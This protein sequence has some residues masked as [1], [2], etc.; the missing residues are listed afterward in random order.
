MEPTQEAST[1]PEAVPVAVAV[2]PGVQARAVAVRMVRWLARPG[3]A[4]TARYVE[5]TVG[6][7]WSRAAAG[8]SP[9]GGWLDGF[10]SATPEERRARVEGLAAWLEGAEVAPA[11]VD[12]SPRAVLLPAGHP[13]LTPRGRPESGDAPAGGSAEA[14]QP[15]ERTGRRDRRHDRHERRDRAERGDAR[16]RREDA[17]GAEGEALRRGEPPPPHEEVA[18]RPVAPAAPPPPPEPRTFPLGHPEGTGAALSTLGVLDDSELEALGAFGLATIS[19]LLL[20]PPVAVDR[21]GE[22]W[23]PQSAVGSHVVV[24]GVVRRRCVRLRPGVR[25]EELT[26][27]TERG[28]E[29]ACRWYG[30]VAPEVAALR[31]GGEVGLSGALE[32]EDDAHVLLQAEV[33][34][35]DGRGGDWFPRYE[36]PGVPD[37]R[38]RSALRAAFRQHLDALADHLPPELLEKHRLMPLAPAVRDAHFPPNAG[39]KGRSRLG[40]DELLQVQLGVALLRARERRDRGLASPVSHALLA[41]AQGMADSVFTDAQEAALDDIRRDLRRSQPMARLL[42]GDVGVGKHAVVQAAML[43]VAEAKHQAVFVAPDAVT[44]EHRFLFAEGFFRSVGIEPVLLLGAPSKAQQEQLKKGE[45]LVLYATPAILRDA[46]AFRK[47]GLVVVEE[48]GPYGVTDVSALEAGGH[49]PDVL[50]FTPT[51]VPS[52]IALNLY[53][54]LSLTVM[55]G[56]AGRGVDTQSLDAAR[57]DEAYTIAREAIEA[58]QQVILAFPLVRGQDL[59]SPSEARRLAEVLAAETFPGAKIGIFSGGMSREERFRAYDDFQH[60]RTQVLLAT[61]YVEHGPAVP[62]ATV[63]IVEY[64]E[65]FDLVRLHRLRG[66]VAGGWRRG[67]CLLV[68]AESVVEPEV[69]HHLDLLLQETDGFRIAELDLRH[70]GLEAVLGERA[71]D[72]PDFAWAD[73][74]TERDLLVRTRQE[75]MRILAS[76]GG[77]KRRNHRALLHL[78][79]SR[80]GE[81]IAGEGFGDAGGPPA[82]VGA[83]A[84]SGGPPNGAAAAGGA[85]RR[86][87]RRGR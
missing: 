13:E 3:V 21:A 52:A 24:R 16:A 4:E 68:T 5:A 78:V 8:D 7:W 15:S 87:R 44:A 41:R 30:A 82:R 38:V 62:N 63:M 28:A 43:L 80:F 53:G 11:D 20:Q 1:T 81:D 6:P 74:V 23:S 36:V 48:H 46:P 55:P 61:T 33:L 83:P 19:D 34:G 57:R 40:F 50:V 14:S 70:R 73:P 77:L 27:V 72:A 86:R 84:A 65:R 39:R 54:A 31:A 60:Q 10:D 17:A 25:R 32:H 76:D 12:S 59:L 51:P 37:S 75:A 85:R 79:R 26:L 56:P 35:M 18:S 2:D 66:H 9:H 64:A 58:G 45:A 22:R 42:Q 71:A 67:R 49:R 69:Q 47:L 29:V